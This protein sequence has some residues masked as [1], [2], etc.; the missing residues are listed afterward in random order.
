MDGTYVPPGDYKPPKKQKKVY[1][2]YP[3]NPSINFIGL[4]IGPS[5]TTQ[6]K[7]EKESKCKISIRG[8]G[9]QTK[10]YNPDE[11]DDEPLHVLVTAERS[12][13]LEKGVA[14]IEAIVNQTDEA[15]KL[16][17]VLMDI[18]STRKVWCESCG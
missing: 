10:V 17:L 6:Q 9:S 15:K 1:I 14:M 18:G 2:P 12:E 4:I 16:P 7:L 11:K 13:D 3:D 8:K 5:G